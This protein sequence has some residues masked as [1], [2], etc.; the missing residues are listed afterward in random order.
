[1]WD[2]TGTRWWWTVMCNHSECY[3]SSG[4]PCISF[5]LTR[6]I[7]HLCYLV[8]G[9]ALPSWAPCLPWHTIQLSATFY[10]ASHCLSYLMWGVVRHCHVPWLA[11]GLAG[12]HLPCLVQGLPRPGAC[13]LPLLVWGQTGRCCLPHY[14]QGLAR[15]GT[16]IWL[17]SCRAQPGQEL[18]STL[19]RPY[20]RQAPPSAT[21]YAGL[22]WV[23]L[24]SF[25]CVGVSCFPLGGV[26]RKLKNQLTGG[27]QLA[28]SQ[29]F[30]NNLA[31]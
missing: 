10:P 27:E 7:G 24:S 31:P 16:A 29:P 18:L 30:S 19:C 23:L 17:I 14:A 8:K 3:S 1:M 9:S 15:L 4:H 21:H 13:Y 6:L 20:L 28:L 25:P 12:C 22:G 26:C 11:W 5:T 2:Y